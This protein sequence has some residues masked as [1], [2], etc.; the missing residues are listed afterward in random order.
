M[1]HTKYIFSE[2]Y[3]QGLS[4]FQFWCNLFN[5]VFFFPGVWVLFAYCWYWEARLTID[6]CKYFLKAI[7]YQCEKSEGDSSD[8]EPHHSPD[9][10]IVIR[11][12][13]GLFVY[14]KIEQMKIRQH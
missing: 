8:Y 2:S 14:C 12:K 13:I 6:Q 7:T 3:D 4:N 10:R 1:D 5:F 9:I 11:I